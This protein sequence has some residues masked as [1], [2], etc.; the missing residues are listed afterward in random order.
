[1]SGKV[2]IEGTA[3]DDTRLGSILIKS[4]GDNDSFEKLA[5][6]ENGIWSKLKDGLEI[7]EDFG[8]TQ[9]GHSVK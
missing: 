3:W 1:M 5:A 2:Y 8:I 4:P 6:F 9:S 7:L